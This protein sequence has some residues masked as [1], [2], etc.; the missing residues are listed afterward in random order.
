MNIREIIGN[1]FVV[2]HRGAKGYFPEN[3][4][5]SFKKAVEMGVDI[6]ELDVHTT[7]DDIPIIFHNDQIMIGGNPISINDLRYEDINK[8]VV[9]DISIPIF[10]DVIKYLIKYVGVF[11]DIKDPLSLPII[12][13]Y[14]V[15]NGFS[16]EVAIISFSA[17]HLSY[18]KN[19][20]DI[21]TGY[22][23]IKADKGIVLA[24]KLGCEIILPYFRLASEKAIDFAHR[25]GLKVVV[26][27]LNDYE[28]AVEYRRRGVDGIAT[29]YPDKILP[30][31]NIQ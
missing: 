2:G 27:T 19:F 15:N 23:Y 24:K 31:K 29:D 5:L 4:M 20:S 28:L 3:T 30:V 8:S 18:V 6:V 17:D 12:L 11:I 10:Y 22:I 13:R 16:N 14:I 1:F 21:I 26:W 25:L 9:G 7:K